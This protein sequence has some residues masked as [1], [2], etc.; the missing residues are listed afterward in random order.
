MKLGKKNVIR[1]ETL[2]GVGLI[3]CLAIGLFVQKKGEW[4]PTQG[5]EAYL[6]GKVPST[7]SVVKD[8][9][10]DTLVLYDSENETSQ[11]AWK[12]F[13][14]ILKDMRMGAKLVDV[15]KH[16]SYSLSDYKK[17]VLLVTDLSRMEDQVQPLMD[18]TEKGGQTLFAVTMGKESNLDA[19]DHNLGVSYSN[20]EMDEV[21]EIYVDPDFM[22]G[23]GRNYKIEEPFESARKVS[24]ESDVKVHAKTT[25][26]SHT[27]LI[28]EKSYGK[29]KFVVDNLGIYE[30][31]V[32]GI[33]AA[34]YSLLTEATVYPVINGSTYYIDDFPSP[35]PAGDG[36]FVKRD[37]DMS[38]SEFYT[39]VWWP[40]LLKLHEKYGIVHTGVVIENYEAQTDGKIVQQN[41]LDR[42][43]YFGN[44]L[45][46][47][48]GELG[49]HGYNHQPLSPSSVNYGEKYASYKTWKDKAAMKASL[50]EL[51]RFVNQLFPKAQKSVYVPPSN[52]L[53]KEGREVIVNDFPEIKAISSNYFPGDFTYSQEL[54]VS[55]EGMI[56]EPRTVS[57][58]VGDDF[59]QM[60][61][62]SEMNMHYVNNHFL[63]PDDV[64]D[65]DRGAELGWAKMY[66]ALD[67]EVSWVHN[68]SPSLRNLT[69]SELAGA[70][71]RYGIL[72]VSQKYTKDALKIDLENFHDHA[73]LMVRLNQN[74]VKKVKNGKV[75]HLTGDLYLLEATN[76]S[77]TITLK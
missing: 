10:K 68:M 55:P 24:L 43:K 47:N 31:N 29:G 27:P 45:L 70:V 3:L 42:F 63:H 23:G 59:S 41:D 77:V 36:R 35:V 66:K 57:G 25:D 62:F 46:A 39:N 28:W 61:V 65:V 73:Y 53:S 26:D 49:Y 6:T 32:R 54:E 74:E 50:S 30:R 38:V 22:I 18:W 48:G 15:A 9:D 44:S 17:V 71:Q 7:A 58:A 76:K 20:F 37:Y 75:T 2:L 4:Y 69:G 72:K 11:R 16:E 33:Y 56:E 12:Q 13:E 5:K 40:D 51:I 14:Q 64:L 19:I 67:K 60:T 34:S 52:I 8:L 21:K 1:K